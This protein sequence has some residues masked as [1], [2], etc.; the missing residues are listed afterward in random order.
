MEKENEAYHHGNLDEALVEETI[1]IVRDEGL[2]AV[3]MR[4]LSE[5]LDVSRSAAYRHFDGKD[6][7]FAEVAKK[8]FVGLHD[9]MQKVRTDSPDTD[10][11][12]ERLLSMGQSYVQYALD[13]P[14]FYRLMFQ[15]N[16]SDEEF[17]DLAN[18]AQTAFDEL[19]GVIETGQENGTFVE[20]DTSEMA[21]STWALVHG[22]ALLALEGHA[23]DV[24]NDRD[25]LRSVISWIGKGLMN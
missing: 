9:E 11:V 1:A 7:L 16:W 18:V 4:K 25:R 13:N 3:S 10:T 23:P 12:F 20:G 6:A 14:A 2:K 15:W 22:V 8:G 24:V 5:K 17:E 21:F 19:V